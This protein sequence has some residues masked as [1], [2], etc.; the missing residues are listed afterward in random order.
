MLSCDKDLSCWKL[1][2][3]PFQK[4]GKNNRAEVWWSWRT[5]FSDLKPHDK[6][7]YRLTIH[8]ATQMAGVKNYWQKLLVNLNY[9]AFF[10]NTLKS[11]YLVHGATKFR[12]FPFVA[13]TARSAHTLPSTVSDSSISHVFLNILQPSPSSPTLSNHSTSIS[14]VRC[15]NVRISVPCYAVQSF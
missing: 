13:W 3:L 14:S 8:R 15:R 7:N 2:N 1:S 9:S 6:V 11:N 5:H 12:A 4:S 10:Y